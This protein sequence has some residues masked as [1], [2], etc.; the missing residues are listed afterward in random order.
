MSKY[1]ISE[2]ESKAR[3]L[4][5][6]RKSINESAREIERQVRINK[7]Y[8]INIISAKRF[9]FSSLIAWKK[10]CLEKRGFSSLIEYEDYRARKKGLKNHKE[11]REQECINMGFYGKADYHNYLHHKNRGHVKNKEEYFEGLWRDKFDLEYKPNEYFEEIS[12]EKDFSLIGILENE[13]KKEEI[14]NLLEKITAK[15]PERDQ[16]VIRARFYEGKTYQEIGKELKLTR[17][18]IRQIEP[19]AIRKLYLSARKCGLHEFC[20][21]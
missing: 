3:N 7:K 9:G 19:K 11:L 16:R 10:S 8:A 21:E 20:T 17:E 12:T 1:M 18:R 6:E 15:L 13:D 2:L 4:D 5:D 14:K